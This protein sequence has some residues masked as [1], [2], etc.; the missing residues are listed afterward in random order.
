M[1][2]STPLIPKDRFDAHSPNPLRNSNFTEILITVHCTV[3]DGVAYPSCRITK[4]DL[5]VDDGEWLVTYRLFA[6]R[7]VKVLGAERERKEEDCGY[8]RFRIATDFRRIRRAPKHLMLYDYFLVPKHAL[9]ERRGYL[10]G[11]CSYTTKHSDFVI[12]KVVYEL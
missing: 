6:D 1:S 12:E 2:G 3:R 7:K 9:P 4:F 11:R 5:D 8:A 10:F